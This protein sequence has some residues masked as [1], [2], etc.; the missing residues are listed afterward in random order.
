MVLLLKNSNKLVTIN[1]DF[2]ELHQTAKKVGVK[3][4]RDEHYY[5]INPKKHR[6]PLRKLGVRVVSYPEAFRLRQE[7]RDK[8]KSLLSSK[9]AGG[10]G[11]G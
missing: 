8:S 3:D 2:D 5:K 6:N 1:N 9:A 11:A 4:F 7:L 10:E